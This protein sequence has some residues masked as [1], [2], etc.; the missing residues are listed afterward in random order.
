MSRRT[1]KVGTSGRFGPRYGVKLRRRI[2]ALE[3]RQKKKH[4][5]PECQYTAVK[6]ISTGIWACRHCGYK[7]TGGA[8]LP[9]TAVGESK[10]ESIQDIAED[11]SLNK[12]PEPKTQKKK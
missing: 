7:F 1:K 12:K 9:T 11:S 5:C 8:Y 6:R 2:G 3:N 4:V 10:L